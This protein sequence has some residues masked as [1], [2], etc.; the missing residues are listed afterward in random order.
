MRRIARTDGNQQE[1]MN[2]LRTLGASVLDLHKVGGGAPDILVGIAIPRPILLPA[3]YRLNLLA[4]IKNP[5]RFPSQ[6][7]LNPLET[8]FHRDWRGQ[9]SVIE[10]LN[11]CLKLL[12]IGEYNCVNSSCFQ[13]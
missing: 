3:G 9:I 2:Y 8:D 7:K 13:L 11:D 5:K 1:L 4:E 12:K 6:R 10:T